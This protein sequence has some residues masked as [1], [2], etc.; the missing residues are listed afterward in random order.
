MSTKSTACKIIV[1]ATASCSSTRGHPD[2]PCLGLDEDMGEEVDAVVSR[3]TIEKVGKDLGKDKKP[4]DRIG[5]IY[6]G[7]TSNGEEINI[8]FT[9]NGR[10]HP[11]PR[12]SLLADPLT[13][14]RRK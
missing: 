1:L 9:I 6:I 10:P 14:S 11:L 3:C 2:G 5:A 7:D 4:N 13:A 12:V 8:L